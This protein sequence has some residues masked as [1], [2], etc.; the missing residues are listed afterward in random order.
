MN[1]LTY[2][3]RLIDVISAE[4][5]AWKKKKLWSLVGVLA[6]RNA[7]SAPLRSVNDVI[8]DVHELSLENFVLV[9]AK[10]FYEQLNIPEGNKE[11]LIADF[12]KMEHC[13]RR[14]DFEGFSLCVYQQIENLVNHLYD[15][16]GL[17]NKFM[18]D[19]ERPLLTV[20]YG[21]FK[22]DR[23]GNALFTVI[24]SKPYN[25]PPGFNIRNT[26]LD[27]KRAIESG[28]S[29]NFVFM[30]K[31]RLVL[32]Y[33]FFGESVPSYDSWNENTELLS[34]INKARNRVHRKIEEEGDD[35][36][37]NRKKRSYTNY[38]LFAGFLAEFVGNISQQLLIEHKKLD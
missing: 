20:K 10:N 3:A 11:A 24:Y 6:S 21:E 14:D 1:E 5:D 23:K 38:L 37:Q 15:A 22:G 29:V 31:S 17:L 35:A 19:A 4:D 18:A 28:R 7:E 13:K 26:H 16:Y 32:Y 9:Q 25:P 34:Q 2:L 33:N 12:V 8:L 36:V 30:E 27:R